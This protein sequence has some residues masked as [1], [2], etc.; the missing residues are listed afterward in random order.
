MEPK[1]PVSADAKRKLFITK[2]VLFAVLLFCII[3]GGWHANR[4]WKDFYDSDL[5]VTDTYRDIFPA[6]SA[7][8]LKS[9]YTFFNGTSV[10]IATFTD[11]Q[12]SFKLFVYKL[13]IN[14]DQKIDSIVKRITKEPEDEDDRGDI[15]STTTKG[16]KISN[17]K[18]PPAGLKNLRV[19][20][21][22]EDLKE[23]I[24]ND[25]LLSY[26]LEL[27]KLK[28][29]DDKSKLLA[30]VERENLSNVPYYAEVLFYKRKDGVYVFYKLMRTPGAEPEND[31]LLYKL[32]TAP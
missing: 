26:G 18:Q 7:A 29:Y 31:E 16:F 32:F 19:Y 21:S 13:D 8:K 6:A 23:L 15:S 14:S 10:P 9:A 5:E 1:I 3:Y 20:L 11:K 24:K 2:S 4:I 28:V 17:Q 25:T 22:G 27:K 30:T 12:K